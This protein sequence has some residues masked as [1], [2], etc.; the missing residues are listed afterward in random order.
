MDGVVRGRQA[1]LVGR[2]ARCPGHAVGD[3]PIAGGEAGDEGALAAEFLELAT[4]A[5]LERF[6]GQLVGSAAGGLPPSATRMLRGA[7][8]GLARKTQFLARKAEAAARRDSCDVAARGHV[9]WFRDMFDEETIPERDV[10]HEIARRLVRIARH[11]AGHVAQDARRATDPFEAVRAA[12]RCAVTTCLPGLVEGSSGWASAA[13][14]GRWIRRGNRMV[15]V[16]V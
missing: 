13:R 12:L 2:S 4:D 6:F 7:L 5:E 3:R 14:S 16:G 10:D 9:S 11:A 1:F 15:I 8:R